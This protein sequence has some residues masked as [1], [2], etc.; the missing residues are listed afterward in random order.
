LIEEAT[1][2]KV[3]GNAHFTA[4]RTQ[5]AVEAYKEG[6]AILPAKKLPPKTKKDTPSG[7]DNGKGKGR[8]EDPSDSSN[9][10]AQDG[11]AIREI[12]D[13]EDEKAFVAEGQISEEEKKLSELRCTLWN[14]LSACQLKLV[15][16][17]FKYV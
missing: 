5:A 4:Q 8:E 14:N 2:C 12:V 11:G 15:C 13:E 17:S 3:E 7:G 6:L 16:A 9:D 1:K 10:T